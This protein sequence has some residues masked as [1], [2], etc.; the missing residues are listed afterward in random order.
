MNPPPPPPPPSTPK[1]VTF[2][3][4]ELP[5]VSF[6][7][8]W[9]FCCN[10]THLLSRKS[11]FATTNAF[12]LQQNFCHDKH[13]LRQTHVVTKTFLLLRQTLCH[14]KTFVTTSI[15]LSR[16][17]MCL[18]W[19]KIC[20][21]QQKYF[22]RDKRHVLLCKHALVMTKLLSQQKWCMWQLPPMTVTSQTT[23][24]PTNPACSQ[25]S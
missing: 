3:W 17:K 9:Q 19:Q 15:L 4:W 5:Q 22:C 25:Y 10:K 18:L 16:Q 12:L 21:S 20:L 1:Q 8:Q 2:H 13:L 14:N 11:R 7:S 24:E 6:V 23:Y